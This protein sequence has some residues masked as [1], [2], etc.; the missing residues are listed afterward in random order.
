LKLIESHP[1]FNMQLG[2]QHC[3]VDDSMK[4]FTHD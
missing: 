1:F 4:V 3:F 2:A